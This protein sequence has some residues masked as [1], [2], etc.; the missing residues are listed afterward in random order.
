MQNQ[1]EERGLNHALPDYNYTLINRP[2]QLLL[3][4]AFNSGETITCGRDSRS[5]CNMAFNFGAHF[6]K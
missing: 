5:S 1:E 4:L 3:M 6:C 2:A